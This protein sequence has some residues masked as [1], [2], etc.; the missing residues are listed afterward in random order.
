MPELPRTLSHIYVERTGQA[1]AYVSKAG[2]KNAP[3]PPRERRAHAE[4][5]LRSLNAAL[6]EVQAG[7]EAHRAPGDAVPEGFL[8]EFR[9]PVGSEKFV[10]RLEDRRQKIELLSVI[11]RG[12]EGLRASVYVP[13]RAQGHFLRKIQ[14]YR[15]EETKLGKPKNEPLIN[16]V[17][18]ISLGA[19]NSVYTDEPNYLP[20]GDTPTWWEVWL[21]PGQKYEFETAARRL[22]L[23]VS[24]ETLTFPEREVVLAFGSQL[25][26]GRCVAE[27]GTVAEVRAAR[28][29]PSIFLNMPND[30]QMDWAGDIVGRVIPPGKDAVTLCI[31]DSGVTRG[32]PLIAPGLEATDVHKYDPNWP[33]GDSWAWNGHGTAMAGLGLYGDIFP[34]LLG[35]ELVRLSHRLEVVKM[36]AHD[37]AQH[38]PRLYGAITK[39]CASRPE[40]SQPRRRRIH[41]VAITSQFGTNR[42]AHLLGQLLLIRLPMATIT[43]AG[44]SFWPAA[45][46]WTV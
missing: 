39:E 46:S 42:V 19:F 16:R 18:T 22:E 34:L 13:M 17:N 41:C 10:E 6:G 33:D 35:T 14:R 28:D 24:A 32:H 5:L 1:E 30:E 7:L 11:D 27:S 3:P 20:H 25:A 43:F 9:L 44:S 8:L 21:R 37:G 12:E 45:I 36:L 15:D 26:I 40:V 2:G 29:A 23:R 38:E 31:L 4:A